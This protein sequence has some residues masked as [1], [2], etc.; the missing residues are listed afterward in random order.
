MSTDEEKPISGTSPRACRQLEPAN[1]D[2]EVD[3]NTRYCF[4]MK[5]P[6]TSVQGRAKARTLRRGARRRSKA[7]T[8]TS[9]AGHWK[10]ERT[11]KSRR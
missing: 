11:K 2:V 9:S 3:R 6:T 1:E 10:M 7:A 8:S 4:S 5:D